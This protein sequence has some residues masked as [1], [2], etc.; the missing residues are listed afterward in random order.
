IIGRDHR[1]VNNYFEGLRGDGERAG[2]CWMNGI[3]DGPLNGYGPVRNATV[4]HNTFVDCKVS[5]EFC[6]TPSKKNTVV[7]KDC[8][9]S[10]NAFLP[11]KWELFRVHGQPESFAWSGNK[12]QEGKTRGA[13]LVDFERVSISLVRASD[14]L[15][16]PEETGLLQTKSNSGVTHDIDGHART[17]SIAGCDDPGNESVDRRWAATCGPSWR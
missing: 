1:V 2:V 6:V 7:P 5:M 3:P 8:C 15:L 17:A 14:G 16:R 10:H 4:S 12:Y 11:G 9:V 13:D